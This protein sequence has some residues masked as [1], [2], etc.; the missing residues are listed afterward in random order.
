M[1]AAIFPGVSGMR[2]RPLPER[3]RA[4]TDSKELWILSCF[5]TVRLF[6]ALDLPNCEARR[7]LILRD[8]DKY[9]ILFRSLAV[10]VLVMVTA[11]MEKTPHHMTRHRLEPGT[12]VLVLIYSLRALLPSYLTH[13][14]SNVT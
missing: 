7:L 10:I 4:A 5:V 11:L 1:S 8:Y 13:L 3:A 12:H 6:G 9:I 2:T 14:F